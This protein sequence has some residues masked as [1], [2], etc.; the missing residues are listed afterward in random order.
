MGTITEWTRGLRTLRAFLGV[1]YGHS[2]PVFLCPI[3]PSTTIGCHASGASGCIGHHLC[4]TE[5][6]HRT[7][8]QRSRV[9][10]RL[11]EV[12][13]YWWES[14]KGEEEEGEEIF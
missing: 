4:L 1:T 13:V 7:A 8:V 6:T 3:F 14:E 9:R 10:L 2:S 11:R 12:T 5:G